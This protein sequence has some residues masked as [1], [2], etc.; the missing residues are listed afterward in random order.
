MDEL[1]FD[2][3]GGVLAV[4][5][6][7]CD[8]SAGGH[9][10]SLEFEEQIP[11]FVNLDGN[12]VAQGDLG[13]VGARCNLVGAAQDA[14]RRVVVD[15]GD[16]RPKVGIDDC[17]QWNCLPLLAAG[18]VGNRCAAR[19]VGKTLSQ[20]VIP[21]CQVDAIGFETQDVPAAGELQ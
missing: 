2:F 12:V 5:L 17:S 16:S 14:P 10:A 20:H 18:V 1:E 6:L 19:C 21:G 13:R 15:Q 11:S 9:L 4:D 3:D 7:P 8:R